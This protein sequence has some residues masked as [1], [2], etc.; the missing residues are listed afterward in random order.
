[1]VGFAGVVVLATRKTAGASIGWAVAAGA[2]AAFLYGL[3]LNLVRR[4]PDRPAAGGG[5]I[6]PRSAFRRC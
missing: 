6:G 2:G 5:G 3:G 4:P 1:M